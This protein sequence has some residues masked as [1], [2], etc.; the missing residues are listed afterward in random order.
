MEE[1]IKLFKEALDEIKED[2]DKWSKNPP[3]EKEIKAEW[4][5][6]SLLVEFIQDENIDKEITIFKNA[7]AVVKGFSEFINIGAMSTI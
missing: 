6:F 3:T 4:E 1:T 5:E 7:Q 2:F